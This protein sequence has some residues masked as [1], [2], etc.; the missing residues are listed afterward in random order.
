MHRSEEVAN[1]V[2]PTIPGPTANMKSGGECRNPMDQIGAPVVQ[3]PNLGIQRQTSSFLQLHSWRN[4]KSFIF[5]TLVSTANTFALSRP[6]KVRVD[7]RDLWDAPG[8]AVGKS[9]DS[10]YKTLGHKIIPEVEWPALWTDL[11]DRFPEKEGFVPAVVAA[12]TAWYERLLARL[13]NSVYSKWTDELLE[14]LSEASKRRA[15]KLH[16]QV[17]I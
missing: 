3:C 10:L 14:T 5:Y 8:A 7:I 13:E 15:P 4:C 6:L 11:A 1:Y 9:V 17:S 2:I 12:S 16:I